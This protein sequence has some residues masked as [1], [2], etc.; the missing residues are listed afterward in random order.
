MTADHPEPAFRSVKRQALADREGFDRLV[1]AERA[2]AEKAGGV[3]GAMAVR[4]NDDRW[5]ANSDDGM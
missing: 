3:N 4:V 5:C 2:G 1:R